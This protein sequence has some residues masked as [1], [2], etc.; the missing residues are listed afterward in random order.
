MLKLFDCCILYF[1]LSVVDHEFAVWP[2][3]VYR[4]VV[5]RGYINLTY[6]G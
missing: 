2:D 5:K 6:S 3:V 4:R 1:G